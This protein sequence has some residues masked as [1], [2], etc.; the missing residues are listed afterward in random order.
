[1]NKAKNHSP[2]W[3]YLAILSCLFVLS[4]TAP[5]AWQ[6]KARQPQAGTQPTA[7]TRQRG[8]DE[9]HA[10]AL[11]EDEASLESTD[12]VELAP[13]AADLRATQSPRHVR[14]VA[15]EPPAG[16]FASEVRDEPGMPPAPAPELRTTRPP[17]A[18]P[19]EDVCL[20]PDS[21]L[22]G[23]AA[24]GTLV[25]EPAPRTPALLAA[26]PARSDVPKPEKGPTAAS[27]ADAAPD[28]LLTEPD[29]PAA[30]ASS[31]WPLPRRLL[32]QLSNLAHEDPY[33]VW[34]QR[35]IELVHRLSR[36]SDQPESTRQ[37]LEALDR[38]ENGDS[39]MPAADPALE[40]SIVRARYALRRWLDLWE[41]AAEL[42]DVP[43]EDRIDE[44][45]AKRITALLAEFDA[46]AAENPAE[47]SAWR[48]YLEL[49][50]L[51]E[52]AESPSGQARRDAARNVL[53]R[54]TSRRLSR[55]Q[56]AFL[57]KAPLATLREQLH[58][59]AAEPITSE[60]VLRHIE[61]YEHS[62]MPS[63]AKLVV[64]DLRSLSW[65]APEQARQ[66]AKYLDAHYRNANMRV[67]AAGELLNL[68]VPQPGR[69]EAQVRDTVVNV[70]VRGHASTFTRLS[71]R[72]VPDERRIRLGLEAAGTVDSNTVSTAGP[73][74]FRNT[75][76]STFLVRKLFVLGPQGLNVWPA[77]AEAENN[78]SYLV[79]LETDFDRVPLV[80]SLIRGIAR[81]QHDEMRMVARRH[82][83]RKV[84]ERALH[85]LDNEVQQRLLEAGKKVEEHQVATLH[86]LGL[87]LVPISLQ[88]TEDRVVARARLSSGVQLGAHTPR[89]RAPSDSWLS[90]QTHQTVLNNGLQQ[91][92][93]DGQVFELDSLFQRIADKLARPEIAEQEDLPEDVRVEFADK[94]AIT[95][96]CRD[97]LIEVT[98]AFAELRHAGSLWRNFRVRTSYVP[99]IEGL[100][101]RL[102]R[103]PDDTIHLEGRSLRGKIAFKLRAIFSK[104]LS[105]NRQLRLL[106]DS[107]TDDERLRGLQITQ[108]KVEDGWIGLAYSPRRVSSKVA[109]K[110]E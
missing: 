39:L 63:D 11:V 61:Q 108:F 83:E 17:K 35:A 89:P 15:I 41:S 3:P 42:H 19:L 96:Q 59:W 24:P 95:V 70:P 65:S 99:K 76:Q 34:P 74:T 103:N 56:R 18:W 87:E 77:I 104:V 46:L 69:I 51:A 52:A 72:L 54:M 81:S 82:T 60:R 27:E 102:V 66:L 13:Y 44:T 92:N 97:G 94:D 110:P 57:D 25:V 21:T 22:P 58:G 8:A 20:A 106:D 62:G 9:L 43:L 49:D 64:E 38:I 47:G 101:P 32:E 23:L 29:Y 45:E 10:Q 109:R 37:I 1:M 107:I 71:I 73:A 67:A 93:L 80:G 88:T 53:D 36:E 68:F 48:E 26:Q 55:S 14:E 4:L 91:L 100:S 28:D 6:R 30:V 40:G 2:I 5:R 16:E 85:E 12:A 84:A 33:L 105:P 98:L 7:G 79:S 90:L 75:G 50:A 78:Y 86:R 31:S